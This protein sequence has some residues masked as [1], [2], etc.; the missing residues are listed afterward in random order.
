VSIVS[1]TK[2]G[3]KAMDNMSD[4]D[5]EKALEECELMDNIIPEALPLYINYQWTTE[6]VRR[7]YLGLLEDALNL[8]ER[9]KKLIENPDT[10]KFLEINI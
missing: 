4:G 8:A 2:K 9:N 5:I 1:E 10:S 3:S 7:R 6:G